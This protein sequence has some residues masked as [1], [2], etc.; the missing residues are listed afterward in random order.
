M[1]KNGEKTKM[2]MFVIA[3]RIPSIVLLLIA[4]VLCNV[5]TVSA[6]NL[7]PTYNI[8]ANAPVS[9]TATSEQNIV[10]GFEIMSWVTRLTINNISNRNIKAI[11]VTYEQKD[12][13]DKTVSLSKNESTITFKS[14]LSPGASIVSEQ[15]TNRGSIDATKIIVTLNAVLFDDGTKWQQ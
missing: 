14:V 3:G 15:K 7:V 10:R 6:G 8:P 11:I 13:N 12:N 1:K 4:T 9:V 5:Y 2:G